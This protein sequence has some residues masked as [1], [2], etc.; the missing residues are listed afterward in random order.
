MPGCARPARMRASPCATSVRLTRSRL[1]TSATVPSA[2]RSSSVAE[3]G[4]AA[5]PAKWPRCAQQRAGGEQHVEHD[6]HAGEMLP[7]K[8]AS[9]LIRIHDQRGRRKR[10]RRQVMIG[11]QHLDA[12]CGRRRDA[13]VARDAV[14]DGHD[15]ARRERG[16]GLIDDFRREPVAVL[17]AIRHE[18]IDDGAHRRETA[19]PDRACGGAIGIV[20]GDDHDLLAAA[21]RV[22]EARGGVV[23]ALHRREPRQRREI[24]ARARRRSPR[25]GRRTRAPAPD[26]RR[27]RPALAAAAGPCGA[28]CP[29]IDLLSRCRAAPPRSWRAYRPATRCHNPGRRA[30]QTIGVAGVVAEQRH[31]VERARGKRVAGRR[32][33]CA[34]ECRARRVRG[35]AR[36]RSNPRCAASP[37]RIAQLAGQG[38]QRSRPRAL[39]SAARCRWRRTSRSTAPAMVGAEASRPRKT[40][41]CSRARVPARS[42]STL[43]GCSCSSISIS[44]C[45]RR[46][47]AASGPCGSSAR[48]GRRSAAPGGWVESRSPR[49]DADEERIGSRRDESEPVVREMRVQSRDQRIG[50][51]APEIVDDARELHIGAPD[52][53][54]H[55]IGGEPV[56]GFR[57]DAERREPDRRERP[58]RL[59]HHAIARGQR[60]GD[61]AILAR[62]GR[63]PWQEGAQAPARATAGVLSAR[64]S[65]S[66]G[67]ARMS[68]MRWRCDSERPDAARASRHESSRRKPRLA[69]DNRRA[70]PSPRAVLT[71]CGAPRF[72]P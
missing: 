14:V 68:C 50:V 60:C 52:L 48:N 55:G 36:R 46:Q 11:D 32:R 71:C 51:G 7:G 5:G 64:R 35:R 42:R 44:D 57:I 24:D 19:H 6:A 1:T 4:L 62:R 56:R 21:Y 37:E 43:T 53:E 65:K 40:R 3:I 13:V 23:D 38:A 12:E 69:C 34:L 27:R 41:G 25:R 61:A 26:A 54:C 58:V 33:P 45:Q 29:S 63:P 20:V 16:C 9:G 28:R 2:T 30:C 70:P 22:G 59:P 72:G 15:E 49:R 8:G 66:A 17:E 31:R 10:G 39:A 47:A 67:S 18:E